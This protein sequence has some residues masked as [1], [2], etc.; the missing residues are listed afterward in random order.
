MFSGNDHIKC[1]NLGYPGLVFKTKW[2]LTED[3]VTVAI[4]KIAFFQYQSI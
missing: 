4:G 3:K 2:L 1:I